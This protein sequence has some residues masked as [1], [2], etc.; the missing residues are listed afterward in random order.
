MPVGTHDG[1]RQFLVGAFDACLDFV[2]RAFTLL[3]Q[4]GDAGTQTGAI[5]LELL[6]D[7]RITLLRIL[8]RLLRFL[9]GLVDF[10]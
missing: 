6:E 3:R 10:L 2:E 8:Q 7:A 5:R 9:L 1:F 4:F